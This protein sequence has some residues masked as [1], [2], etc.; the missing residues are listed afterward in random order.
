MFQL[1]FLVIGTEKGGSTYLLNCLRQHPAI[2]MPNNEPSYFDDC[3]YDPDNMTGLS[4]HFE[5]DIAGKLLGIKRPSMLANPNFSR[6]AHTHFPDAKM[7]AVLRHPVKRALS[8]YVHHRAINTIPNVSAEE[9]FNTV[10]KSEITGYPRA[11]NILEYGLYNKHLGELDRYYPNDQ[12][13]LIILDDLKNSPEEM[14]RKTYCF[15]GV[16]NCFKP[17]EPKIKPMPAPYSSIKTLYRRFM[18]KLIYEMNADGYLQERRGRG[19]T[20]VQY[21]NRCMIRMMDLVLPRGKPPK[22]SATLHAKLNNF[23]IDDI[24]AL[25][26]RL[27]R[28]LDHWK[29]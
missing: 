29:Q 15:L 7:V 2:Y 11:K 8:A 3:F 19:H 25:E 16:D 27:G 6:R 26:K 21:Y 12:L 23:Y 1:D 5:G 20:L 22:L 17:K 24:C 4:E 18:T 28:K 13:L 10:L 9:F 14:I